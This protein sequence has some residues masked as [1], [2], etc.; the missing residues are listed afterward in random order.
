MNASLPVAIETMRAT[1]ARVLAED[2]Q[3]PT[4]D[5]LHTLTLPCEGHLTLLIPEVLKAC[6]G[7]PDDDTLTAGALKGVVQA[8]TRL[9]IVPGMQWSRQ[10]AHAQRLARS[11]DCLLGHLENLAG[12][13]T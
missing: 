5:E 8:R 3:P 4:A 1:A 10:V 13:H 11:V 2:A 6:L 12:K 7:R 9:D